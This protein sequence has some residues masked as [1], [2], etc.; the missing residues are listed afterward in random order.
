MR[1]GGL[2]AA[3]LLG[4][5]TLGQAAPLDPGAVA[6]DAKWVAHLDVDAI[7]SSIVV[8]KAYQEFVEKCPIAKVAVPILDGSRALIGMD[9]RKDL[10]GITLYGSQIGKEEGVLIV[11]ADVD[12][13]LLTEKVKK[14]RGY[15]SSTYGSYELHS[16]THKDHR[17]ERPVTGA[18]YKDKGMV[19]SGSE[20]E[21]KAALD[22]MDGEKPG[23]TCEVLAAEVPAGT[24][25]LARVVGIA[26][27]PCESKLAKEIESVS[28]V[29]G[30]NEGESFLHVKVVAK[31]ADVAEQMGKVAEGLRALGIL[32]AIDCPQDKEL[33]ENM[34]VNV[35]DKTL[36]FDSS[37]PAETVWQH[38]QADVKKIVER[39][40]EM[41]RRHGGKSE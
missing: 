13:K 17:G 16:W 36:T 10:H 21:V 31:S 9:P 24:T 30:E 28:I 22:V 20:A 27:T 8:Q 14:A 38:V 34:K 32:H 11:F 18:F 39:H 23:L 29:T 1:I 5:A 37:V 41:S 12:Q 35:A 19:F 33:V 15:E 25:V 3:I 40:R 6:G 4:L 2:A 7:R 26:E